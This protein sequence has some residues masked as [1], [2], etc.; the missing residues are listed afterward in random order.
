MYSEENITTLFDF[1]NQ[2]PTSYEY[3]GNRPSDELILKAL[4]LVRKFIKC[5]EPKITLGVEGID[6]IIRF[7]FNVGEFG[8]VQYTLSKNYLK[9]YV[10][11]DDANV[12]V[13][14]VELELND[15]DSLDF[16]TRFY[17]NRIK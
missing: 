1:R 10:M 14:N 4:D 13:N 9:L 15:Y 5:P 2:T 7:T 11:T 6:T 17:I 12:L 16:V 3:E 8:F